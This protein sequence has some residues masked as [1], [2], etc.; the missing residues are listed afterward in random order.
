MM[1]CAIGCGG[2]D[3]GTLTAE[4]VN[5]EELDSHLIEVTHH[6]DGTE[7]YADLGEDPDYVPPPDVDDSLDIGS[8]EQALFRYTS[9][10]QYGEYSETHTLP[11]GRCPVTWS[12]P[13]ACWV[14]ASKVNYIYSE[15]D[16][17]HDTLA[18]VDIPAA[19]NAAMAVEIGMGDSSASEWQ[20][21]W[22]GPGIPSNPL[23][24][25]VIAFAAGTECPTGACT[26]QALTSVFTSGGR[27]FRKYTST[28]GDYGVIKIRPDLLPYIIGSSASTAQRVT[29]AANIIRHE[30]G[31][32]KGHGHTPNSVYGV[33]TPMSGT[34]DAW[35]YSIIPY[36]DAQTRARIAYEP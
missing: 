5:S 35:R 10:A 32:I 31:H 23:R 2:V 8:A 11:D 1:L 14:P 30:L 20:T 36:A 28:G 7:T 21:F 3:D 12:S 4:Q 29:F 25:V 33:P 34:Q 9:I 17:S 18:T 26:T 22:A 6:L 13:G 27:R 15:V 19:L 24:N 16:H